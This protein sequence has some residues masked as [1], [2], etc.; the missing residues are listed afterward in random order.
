M[1][2]SIGEF[3]PDAV[4][5]TP[6]LLDSVGVAC[7]L[8]FGEKSM[9]SIEDIKPYRI[10]KLTPDIIDLE[11]LQMLQAG[12]CIQTG[13][14]L[15]IVQQLGDSV[16]IIQPIEANLNFCEF[17]KLLKSYPVG[18]EWCED[19]ELREA[20]FIFQ[21]DVQ[22]P[23]QYFCH[24]G[25]NCFA[26]PIVVGERTLAVFL[27]GKGWDALYGGPPKGKLKDGSR[28]LMTWTLKGLRK[29]LTRSQRLI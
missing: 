14:S 12:F 15:T 29:H 13:E 22:E 8:V 21:E 10:S 18:L 28:K 7:K 11:V 6:P 4:F 23:Y 9:E 20:H 16:R 24:A 1:N 27:S 2:L 3:L 26:F 5:L 19:S 17:C 25:L